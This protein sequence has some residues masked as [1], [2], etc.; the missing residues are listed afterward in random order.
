MYR[1]S[2]HCHFKSSFS[3]PPLSLPCSFDFMN[4]AKLVSV[5]KQVIPGTECGGDFLHLT[6]EVQ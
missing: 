1:Y 6:Y 5:T 2:E 4:M 3:L